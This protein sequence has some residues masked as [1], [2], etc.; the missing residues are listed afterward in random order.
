M[1]S[2]AVPSVKLGVTVSPPCTALSRVTVKVIVSPSLAEA[3]SIV[4]TALPSLSVIV[5]VAMSLTLTVSVVPDTDRLTVKVS[6]ASTTASSLV[7]TA[8]VCVSPALPANV[9]AAVFSV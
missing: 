3:L 1:P 4:T 7:A 2:V 8:N 9:S 6:S 5:P